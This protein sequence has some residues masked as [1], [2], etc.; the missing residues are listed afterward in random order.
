M[1]QFCT[2][3]RVAHYHEKG[4]PRTAGAFVV[5]KFQVERQ[6]NSALRGAN[7]MGIGVHRSEGDVPT[8]IIVSKPDSFIVNTL[9]P[10]SLSSH[11]CASGPLVLE[12]V[13]L[14]AD[15]HTKVE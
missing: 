8:D 10:R 1:P 14:V 6:Q 9:E 13:A 12:V 11:L 3:Q 5:L 4:C 15:H 7:R 2:R